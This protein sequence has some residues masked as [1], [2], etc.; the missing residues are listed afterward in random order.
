MARLLLRS[1]FR[2][3]F[4]TQFRMLSDQVNV[5]TVLYGKPRSVAEVYTPSFHV[6]EI[7]Q[8]FLSLSLLRQKEQLYALRKHHEEEIDHSKK[9][10]E[11]L[12]REIACHKGNIKKLKHDD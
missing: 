11:R 3:F 12:Q 9:E 2:G 8:P 7:N 6:R 5:M 10:I 1:N 4:A